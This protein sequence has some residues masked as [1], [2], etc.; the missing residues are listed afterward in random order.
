MVPEEFNLDGHVVIVA[1]LGCS[2]FPALTLA[3]G[4]GG[5]TIVV[6]RDKSEEHTGSDP[7]HEAGGR[8]IVTIP[9]RLTSETD[10]RRMVRQVVSAYGRI[11]VLI[12]VLN[13]ELLKPFDKISRK[14]W[15]RTIDSNLFANFVC[16]KT[17]GKH[18]VAQRKGSIVNVV[19]G[20]AQRGVI[21]GAAYCASMGGVLQLTRALALEW[22]G[23]QVR[24]NAVGTGWMQEPTASIGKDRADGYIP[25]RRRAQ[26]EDVIPLVLFLASDGST[27]LS[28]NIYMVDGGLMARG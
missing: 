7:G 13:Y 17:V 20:L 25:M 8:D 6:A 16:S 10:V 2:W 24:V 11:D 18:M 23:S 21:N 4:E 26:P 28:G 22:A 9:T 3:L 5:T 12:N 19:S 1:T 27:Y 14:Q 15:S